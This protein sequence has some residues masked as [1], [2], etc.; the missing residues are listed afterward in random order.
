MALPLPDDLYA[1]VLAAAAPVTPAQRGQFLIELAAELQRHPVLGAGL[2][3]RAAAE[4]QRKFLVEARA[5]AGALGET[6]R[7]ERER[8]R[9][10][11]RRSAPRIRARPTA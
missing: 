7:L 3:H 8:S 2:V 9:L 10:I 5:E 11:T 6:R 1:A 4:L